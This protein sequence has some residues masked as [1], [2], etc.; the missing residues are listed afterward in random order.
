MSNLRFI[1]KKR[2][3]HYWYAGKA[4]THFDLPLYEPRRDHAKSMDKSQAEIMA[5]DLA[6]N[7]DQEVEIEPL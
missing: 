1:L 5:K 3:A 7:H 2:G 4:A 6:K